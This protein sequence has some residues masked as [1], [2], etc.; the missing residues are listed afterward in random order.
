ME[1]K[2]RE[3]FE[4]IVYIFL[5]ILVIFASSYGS[6]SIRLIPLLF[7][8]G[9]VGNAIFKRHIMTTILG[10][11]VA[12][13]VNYIK[14]PTDIAYVFFTSASMSLNIIMGEIFGK[15]ILKIVDIAKEKSDN[16]KEKTISICILVLT[17]LLSM[18]IHNFT[19]GSVVT[20]QD[21]KKSLNE[22]L[23]KN[24]TNP[25]KFKEINANYYL[26]KNP[27]YV[28]YLANT[29]INEVYKFTV[30]LNEKDMIIDGY[31]EYVQSSKIKEIDSAITNCIVKLED[32]S[33]YDDLNIKAKF[34]NDDK[35]CIEISK[36]VEK[37]NDKS[38]DSFSKEVVS[39]LED[40]KE[41]SAYDKIEQI[42]LSLKCK[43]Q[44]EVGVA[45]I[46]YLKEYNLVIE[47]KS[48][49][50]YKYI[51]RALNMEYDY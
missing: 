21:C 20:Y 46:I 47:E 2:T 42:D 45:S 38:L 48:D 30:Y 25:E 19:N 41:C 36:D 40:I 39:F 44:E 4:S 32:N 13:C 11:I 51:L 17:L 33:K 43:N 10:F 50:P 12:L 5:I 3:F 49:I 37:I 22:Y 9:I 26:S 28:F 27:R 34:A 6:I 29:D 16:K 23:R 15:Y 1:N 7:I 18:L 8:L 35:V 24:Y 31:K 14:T